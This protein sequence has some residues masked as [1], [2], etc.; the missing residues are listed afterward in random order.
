M[1]DNYLYLSP[2]SQYRMSIYY[3]RYS[4]MY[5]A[6]NVSP[7]SPQL[8]TRRGHTRS[9]STSH[10]HNVHSHT[11]SHSSNSNSTNSSS[12]PPNNINTDNASTKRVDKLE[13]AVFASDLLSYIGVLF[14][15]HNTMVLDGFV[16]LLLHST[17]KVKRRYRRGHSATNTSDTTT[18]TTS[19]DSANTDSPCASESTEDKRG[20]ASRFRD[21]SP[22]TN[23]LQSS[24]GANQDGSN[25]AK[26]DLDSDSCSTAATEESGEQAY[27]HTKD[28]PATE[29]SD[30]DSTSD[31]APVP[32]IGEFMVQLPYVSIVILHSASNL[33]S[34]IQLFNQYLIIILKNLLTT[35]KALKWSRYLRASYQGHSA[36]LASIHQPDRQINTAC[37]CLCNRCSTGWQQATTPQSM[38]GTSLSGFAMSRTACAKSPQVSAV[39]YSIQ[40]CR[41]VLCHAV[42]FDNMLTICTDTNKLTAL[43]HISS[44]VFES[45]PQFSSVS[46]SVSIQYNDWRSEGRIERNVYTFFEPH[47]MSDV[48]NV[49]MWVLEQAVIY[50]PAPHPALSAL[51]KLFP[52][53]SIPHVI[54]EGICYG[55]AGIQLAFE[56]LY[57]HRNILMSIRHACG[58]NP[59]SEVS[60]PASG[61]CS[62]V[63]VAFEQLPVPHSLC[64]W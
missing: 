59:C 39:V 53:S 46:A 32:A 38:G 10:H 44:K 30:I 1:S 43:L 49:C 16:N 8:S 62:C 54:K 19:S 18:S 27:Q 55:V 14:S 47:E 3:H 12:T 23:E 4:N 20:H 35:N 26:S 45:A 9:G 36:P 5:T 61:W 7:T 42:Q 56:M 22:T 33:L 37:V 57:E 2:S 24:G 34:G 29:A 6:G 28:V 64:H 15:R 21:T 48:C 25:A 13:L 17:H 52:D 58:T 41:Y 63:S 50:E 31:E 11:R 60:F 51:V 40:F